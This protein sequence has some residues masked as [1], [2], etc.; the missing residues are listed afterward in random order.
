VLLLAAV[1]L[2]GL[3]AWVFGLPEAA[4]LAVAAAVTVLGCWIWVAVRR[5]ALEVRRTA[6]PARCAV[7]DLCRIQLDVRNLD[8]R[9]SPVV[10][11]HDDVGRHGTAELHL[12]PLDPGATASATYTLPT[13]RRGLQRV[14]PLRTTVEDP[15]GLARRVRVEDSHVTVIVLPRTHPLTPLPPAPGDE[16]EDGVRSAAS[17]STV[18]EEFSTLREYVAGDDIRRIH[19]PTTARHGSPV[20]RE[21][22]LPWQ[23]RTTVVL[24]LSAATQHPS[25]FERTVSVAASLVELAARRGELVR[26]VTTAPD[27]AGAAAPTFVA[28]QDHLDALMDRLAAVTLDER[29]TPGSAVEALRLLPASGRLVVCTG[30]LDGAQLGELDRAAARFGLSVIVTTEGGLPDAGTTRTRLVSWDGTE[31]LEQAWAGQLGERAAPSTPLDA[32]GGAR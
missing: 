3:L 22:D 19:W 23:H 21:F 30:R 2:L 8:Q 31:P 14:G 27:A 7:D 20:V 32:V 6:R 26:L 9:R 18:D 11:L 13:D 10:S 17:L 4:V 5:P 12:G 24:D 16:P 15:F 1:P 25:S 28:A 29:A